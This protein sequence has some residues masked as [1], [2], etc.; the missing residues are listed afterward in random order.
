MCNNN[1]NED[2]FLSAH[3]PHKVG[4]H[5]ALYS[6]TNNIHAHSH[7]RQGDRHSCKKRSLEIIIKRVCLEGGFKRRGRIRVFE[8]NC[9]KQM[10]QREKKILKC[11]PACIQLVECSFCLERLLFDLYSSAFND[12]LFFFSFFFLSLTLLYSLMACAVRVYYHF[13]IVTAAV[14]QFYRYI[15]FELLITMI[16]LSGLFSPLMVVTPASTCSVP[17]SFDVLSQCNG[18]QT[19]FASTSP[20]IRVPTPQNQGESLFLWLFCSTTLSVWLVQVACAW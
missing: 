1:N 4:E 12:F 6:N 16:V 20:F 15:E 18:F 10:G 11:S 14:S 17:T 3:L 9:S 2:D 8:A 19:D 7:V 5:R 13:G